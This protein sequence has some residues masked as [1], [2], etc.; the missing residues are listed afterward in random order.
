MAGVGEGEGEGNGNVKMKK[1]SRLGISME[2]AAAAEDVKLPQDD[3][4]LNL[5]REVKDIISAI[6]QIRDKAHKDDQKRTQHIIN[7]VSSEVKAILEEAKLKYDKERQN[8]IKAATKTCKECD[9]ALKTESSKFQSAYENF[10]KEKSSYLLAYKDIYSKF[11]DNRE[12]LLIQFE[13]Q[14]KKEKNGL[15]DLRKLCADKT[16]AAEDS[17]KKQKR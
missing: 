12:K 10:C 14:R 7:G 15:A 1:R 11:E 17:L 2:M 9:K 3:L 6:H 16:A 5:S 8:F 13:Q 4:D